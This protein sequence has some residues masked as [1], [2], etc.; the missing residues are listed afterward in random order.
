MPNAAVTETERPD[1]DAAQRPG[2]VLFFGPL[3]ERLGRR[4]EIA[5]PEGVATVGDLRRHLAAADPAAETLLD[6]GVR[7]SVDQMVVGDDAAVGPGREI[8][9]FTVFSGG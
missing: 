7:A 9:F 6:A 5:W 8:A 2:V 4:R 3:A 1:A